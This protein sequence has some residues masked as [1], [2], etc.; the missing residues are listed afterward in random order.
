MDDNFSSIVKAVMWGRSVF[1]NIRK[2]LQFQLTV[3]V[4][5]LVLT[6][7]SALT[8][9]ELPL[10]AV[11]M[12]WVN[13]IMDTM[14][15]LAL[16]TE[17]PSPTLLERLPY[18]RNASLI[19]Y[20]MMRNIAIQ[21]IFQLLLLTYLLLYGAGDFDVVEGSHAHLTLIFNTF[22]FCQIFNEFN[23]RSIGDELNVFKGIAK[24]PLFIGIIVFTVVLQYLLVEY[25]G[26][27]VRSVPLTP[28]QFYDCVI[29]G[30]LSITVGG[31]MRFVPVG[32]SADDFAP[33][34]DIMKTLRRSSSLKHRS[35][36][37]L[38]LSFLVWVFVAGA[39]PAL[40][41]QEFGSK[42]LAH[43]QRN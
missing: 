36:Q 21:A 14:G 10:N 32:E 31:L 20:P 23:A 19:S 5:A 25:G 17:P 9:Y 26:D 3:N 38:S 43:I 35:Q 1:D 29:L 24:N 22:V 12:L 34:S 11:M 27:W 30:G 16:G 37:Q 42:W 2:F 6:F 8:G 40:V 7:A 18:K 13:L 28:Q 4:V 15:A 39:F 41:A 33:M